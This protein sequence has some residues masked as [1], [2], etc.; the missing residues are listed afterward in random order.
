MN[1][2]LTHYVSFSTEN[3]D[4]AVKACAALQQ[5]REEGTI[6]YNEGSNSKGQ[7]F[8]CALVAL[9]DGKRAR[10]PEWESGIFIT[11]KEEAGKFNLAM[12][13]SDVDTTVSTLWEPGPASLFAE[14]WEILD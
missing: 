13:N 7:S 10:R 4:A 11:C 2:F 9:K 5:F 14:D 3:E 6:F 1:K 12:I 8:S